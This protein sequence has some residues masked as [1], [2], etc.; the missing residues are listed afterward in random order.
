MTRTPD[1]RIRNPLLCP[2]ELRAHNATYSA[3]RDEIKASGR[4]KAQ[5]VSVATERGS[6]PLRGE[7]VLF[8]SAD[9]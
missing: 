8:T 1:P 3:F 2:A 6:K 4:S 5:Q 9:R 7:R